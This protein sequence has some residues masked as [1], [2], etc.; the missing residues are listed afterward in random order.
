MPICMLLPSPVASIETRPIAATEVTRM[1]NLGQIFLI[2]LPKFSIS[3]V[4]KSDGAIIAVWRI[5]MP[6][7]APGK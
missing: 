4:L 6:T 3:N 5:M 2:A 1:K 7:I